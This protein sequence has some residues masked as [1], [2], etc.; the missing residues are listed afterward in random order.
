MLAVD[1]GAVSECD[2]NILDGYQI[3]WNLYL[4]LGAGER[5]FAADDNLLASSL[6]SVEQTRGGC[7]C[8]DHVLST[9]LVCKNPTESFAKRSGCTRK[10]P[11]TSSSAHCSKR[12][13][14][15]FRIMIAYM[16]IP[17]S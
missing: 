14:Y 3:W 6:V 1:A 4:L 9:P 15:E 8:I 2:A 7:R 10:T 11:T 12:L 5:L 13:Q 16:F 17:Y